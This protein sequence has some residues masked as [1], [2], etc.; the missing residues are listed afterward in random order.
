MVNL[1][2]RAGM[3]GWNI[4]Y[5]KDENNKVYIVKYSNIYEV[6]SAKIDG[7]EYYSE[8]LSENWRKLETNRKLGKNQLKEFK[9]K[10][11]E[12]IKEGNKYLDIICNTKIKPSEIY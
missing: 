4:T 8:G 5:T 9:S 2:I 7:I 10:V 1:E 12:I 3:S 6:Q 11:N